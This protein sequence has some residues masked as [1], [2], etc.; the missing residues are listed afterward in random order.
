V[1][2]LLLQDFIELHIVNVVGA[3]SITDSIIR[4]I[5]TDIS[6]ISGGERVMGRKTQSKK[7]SPK[8]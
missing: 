4:S 3:E 6:S 1:G 2:N 5:I 8:L 7:G